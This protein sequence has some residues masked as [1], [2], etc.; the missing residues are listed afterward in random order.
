M[1]TS[2]KTILKYKPDYIITIDYESGYYFE[3]ENGINTNN[4]YLAELTIQYCSLISNAYLSL[5]ME[6]LINID[7]NNK[8][9]ILQ[10]DT[11]P[12]T[13]YILANNIEG[14]TDDKVYLYD[15]G[16]NENDYNLITDLID[17][18]NLDKVASF[19]IETC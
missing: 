10:E 7:S 11:S 18:I 4:E 9:N 13:N 15:S 17:D 19:I 16:I 1:K 14:L 2:I 5:N 6:L 8:V 12:D 3:D